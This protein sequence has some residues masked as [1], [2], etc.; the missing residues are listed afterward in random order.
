MF[1]FGLFINSLFVKMERLCL[2]VISVKPVYGHC[3]FQVMGTMT[4][5]EVLNSLG[6]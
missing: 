2:L 3:I 5:T 6:P 1:V 4:G